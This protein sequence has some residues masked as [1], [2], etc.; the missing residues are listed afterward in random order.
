M[1]D[2][3]KIT[4]DGMG[5]DD[6]NAPKPPDP[7]PPVVGGAVDVTEGGAGP[8]FD[9]FKLQCLTVIPALVGWIVTFQIAG[10]KTTFGRQYANEPPF[11]AG[12]GYECRIG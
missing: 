10:T 3:P 12:N 4:M 6:P 9:T 7:I 2:T 5:C 1:M 8:V 11:K